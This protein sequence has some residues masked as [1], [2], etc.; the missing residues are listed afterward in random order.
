MF[1]SS[2]KLIIPLEL[3]SLAHCVFT[4]HHEWCLSLWGNTTDK[5]YYCDSCLFFECP[6]SLQNDMA[7]VDQESNVITFGSQRNPWTLV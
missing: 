5:L 3:F 6:R 2:Q 4:G 7:I 1:L